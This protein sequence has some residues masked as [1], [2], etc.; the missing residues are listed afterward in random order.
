MAA[1]YLRQAIVSGEHTVK[2]V[3]KVIATEYAVMELSQALK[4]TDDIKI[5]PVQKLHSYPTFYQRSWQW[6]ELNE[7][8]TR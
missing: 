2:Q 4:A 8:A 3:R 5:D 1:M 7:R 6:Y